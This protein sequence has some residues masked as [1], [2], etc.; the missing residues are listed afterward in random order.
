MP[1]HNGGAGSGQ[2][3][4]R[5]FDPKKSKFTPE[6]AVTQI[7]QAAFPSAALPACLPACLPAAAVG[8]RRRG[9][10]RGSERR[11]ILTASPLR[12][13]KSPG[14]GTGGRQLVPPVSHARLRSHR[15]GFNPAAPAREPRSRG[16][17]PQT[18][19]AGG[20]H[21]PPFGFANKRRRGASPPSSCQSRVPPP[22]SLFAVAQPS[23]PPPFPGLL[24][25]TLP[26][27]SVC[28]GGCGVNAGSGTRELFSC[29]IPGG[30]SFLA[31]QEAD[32]ERRAGAERGLKQV[33][34]E[35]NAFYKA[36]PPPLPAAFN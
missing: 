24:Q 34:R 22:G 14:R 8:G 31:A 25:W 12:H 19:A 10:H 26:V 1:C 29:R 28:V 15:S 35:R 36:D 17:S 18:W 6:E 11:Q 32:A 23:P 2:P 3:R 21:R 20:R 30:A 13:R 5:R 33:R 9:C 27:L 4:R 7:C 16:S